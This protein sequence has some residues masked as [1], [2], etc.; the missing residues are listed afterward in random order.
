LESTIITVKDIAI[1]VND[2]PNGTSDGG[3]LVHRW[4]DPND[5]SQGDLVNGIVK[6]SGLFQ[7]GS[8]GN[9]LVLSS[10]ASTVNNYYKGWWISI[11]SGS[12]ANQARRIKSYTGCHGQ[13]RVRR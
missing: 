1:V 6:E 8:S 4:Q 10:S 11:I 5:L 3:F 9:S 13:S 2:A 12:G 7:S